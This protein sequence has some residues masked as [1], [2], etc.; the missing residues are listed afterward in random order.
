M[1]AGAEGGPQRSGLAREAWTGKLT[2]FGSPAGPPTY[3]CTAI[4]PLPA[5]GS[6]AQPVIAAAFALSSAPLGGWLQDRCELM[7]GM[8]SIVVPEK[9]LDAAYPSV[10]CKCAPVV[11]VPELPTCPM[12]VPLATPVPTPRGLPWS[13]CP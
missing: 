6:K 2:A 12:M 1:L 9:T 13:M 4:A 8:G 10:M 7:K 5:S 11:Q 3:R